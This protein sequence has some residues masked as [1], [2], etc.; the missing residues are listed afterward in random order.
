MTIGG[1]KILANTLFYDMRVSMS[2]TTPKR[3]EI[4]LGGGNFQRDTL[5][6]RMKNR[7][8]K[9][10]LV[11]CQSVRRAVTPLPPSLT[12]KW[13]KKYVSEKYRKGKK[14]QREEC[15]TSDKY[16]TVQVISLEIQ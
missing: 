6:K 13:G 10:K 4:L 1:L 16:R 14:E 5:Y 7:P 2:P 9:I 3:I 8:A 11:C 12:G 15:G